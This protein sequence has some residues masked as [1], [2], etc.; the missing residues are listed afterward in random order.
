MTREPENWY[1]YY[2]APVSPA[3]ALPVLRS[4]QAELEHTNG[5]AARVEERLETGS[6]PTWMEVYEGVTDPDRFAAALQATV[7]SSGL[8]TH[9]LAR[10]IERFRRL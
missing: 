5:I 1:V 9:A 6:T 3:A 10:R 2:P 4:M 8:A 7:D